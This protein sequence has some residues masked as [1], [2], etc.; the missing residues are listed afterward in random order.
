M[1]ERAFLTLLHGQQIFTE[2]VF[3]RHEM[4]HVI[5]LTAGTGIDVG[6]GL[7]KIHSSAIGIDKRAGSKDTGYPFGAQVRGVGDTLPWFEDRSL[8]YVFSS[9]ALE[10]M[11]DTE[12]ALQ[13]WHRVLA[14]GGRL[15]MILPDKRRYPNIG[16]P[17]ANPDHKHDFLPSDIE[18]IVRG[19]GF[20][21][22]QLDTIARKLEDDPWATWE[23]PKYGH[24]SL[25]FSFEVI[26]LK[27]DGRTN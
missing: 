26:A 8:D 27:D 6:C 10:H 24:K 18:K 22:V 9:H 5:H 14:P 15:V 12:A 17:G 7:N 23:A 20:R 11:V 13:E 1:T 21:I 16:Q 3:R 25:N 4:N 19:V 2:S